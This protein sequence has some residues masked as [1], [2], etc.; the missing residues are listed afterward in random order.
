MLEPYRLT[1]TFAIKVVTSGG[2]SNSWLVSVNAKASGEGELEPFKGIYST[3]LKLLQA[4]SLSNLPWNFDD[5]F[6]DDDGRP[7]AAG[8]NDDGRPQNANAAQNQG[9]QRDFSLMNSDLET[10][11]LL[12]SIAT[13]NGFTYKESAIVRRTAPNIAAPLIT[14]TEVRFG[15]KSLK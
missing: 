4:N 12:E 9:P 2:E 14:N 15:S 5:G 7:D 1:R 10:V 8:T 11:W 13:V 6:E 3:R